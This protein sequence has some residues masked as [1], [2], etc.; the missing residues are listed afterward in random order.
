MSADLRK[1][2]EH[3]R[4]MAATTVPVEAGRDRNNRPILAPVPTDAE[5]ALWTRL[6]DEAEARA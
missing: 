3:C 1:F 2:A 5:R 6:A 4:R